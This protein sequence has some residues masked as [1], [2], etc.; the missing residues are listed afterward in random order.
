MQCRCCEGECLIMMSLIYS[1]RRSDVMT[2]EP[3]DLLNLS[4]FFELRVIA[5]K[6]DDEQ[7]KTVRLLC[8][9]VHGFFL[10]AEL[11]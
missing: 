4:E 9:F 10:F 5:E 11:F 8:T 2:P 7:E 3:E 6:M 1:G